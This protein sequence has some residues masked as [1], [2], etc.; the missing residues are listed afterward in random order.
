M[1]P[2]SARLGVVF[3]LC[4][5][6]GQNTMTESGLTAPIDDRSCRALD[7]LPEAVFVVGP[8]G[9]IVHVNNECSKLFGY[10]VEHRELIGKRSELLIAPVNPMLL[11]FCS[12]LSI[13]LAL[14]L[15]LVA[16]VFICFS[17]QE[18]RQQYDSEFA[19]LFDQ[20]AGSKVSTSITGLRKDGSLV[21]LEVRV[22]V[23]REIGAHGEPLAIAL[24][25]ESKAAEQKP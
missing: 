5:F 21:H 11:L 24:V 3:L 23:S 10:H 19:S 7:A 12:S 16:V 25:H 4:G 2:G 13:S 18:K 6:S 14:A 9:D 15:S 22:H 1:A 8:H 17:L 20:P